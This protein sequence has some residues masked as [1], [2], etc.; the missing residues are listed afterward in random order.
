MRT[1]NFDA[2]ATS[3]PLD[4]QASVV[5][6]GSGDSFDG[7]VPDWHSHWKAP[8]LPEAIR[9]ANCPDLSGTR[10]GRL[11]VIRYHGRNPKKGSKWLV[12][13]TCGDYEIRYAP[14][15]K[16]ASEDHK[17]QACDWFTHVQFVRQNERRGITSAGA[18]AARLDDLAAKARGA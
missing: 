1:T 13:C 18:D 10:A 11:T 4:R 17:C 3:A 2:I 5:R 9:P 8:P 16:R 12:R 14:A 7:R 15:I 6:D